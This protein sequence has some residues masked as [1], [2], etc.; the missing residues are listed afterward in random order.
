MS[1][2]NKGVTARIMLLCI[3]LL[4]CNAAI[5]Q[6]VLRITDANS[7]AVEDAF[8]SVK[9]ISFQKE[10][11]AFTDEKGIAKLPFG[12]KCQV[13]IKKL[14][15]KTLLT[16]TEIG[17]STIVHLEQDNH[18]LNDVV[19]T[20]QASAT[21][22]QQSINSIKVIDRKKID[23]MGAVS[24]RDALTNQLNVRLSQDNVLGASA[25][26]Q[27]VGGQGIK[28]LV[29]GVPV[30]G[31]MDGNVDLSQINLSNI[32]RIELIEGPMSVIYGSDALGGVI[33]L[34]S[35]RKVKEDISGSL[36]GYYESNGT[37]NADARFSFKWKEISFTTS[38]G[39]NF[40]DGYSP[41]FDP[42][43]RVVQWKPRTQYF[44]DNT[45]TFKIKQSKHAVF[46]NY[47]QEKITNRGAPSVNP[48]SAYG[49]DEYYY[50]RRWGIGEQSDLYLK[51]NNH[52]QFINSFSYYRRIKNTM[53]KDLTTGNSE[54]TPVSSDD[55]T[56]TFHLYL[57]RGTWTNTA[58]K[59][60]QFQ[61]GYDFNLE[62]AIGQRLE[63]NF[64][65]IQDYA[66]FTTVQYSPI[67]RVSL[68]AGV[69]GAYNTRYGTPVIPSFNLKVDISKVV[70]LR[71]SYAQG[72]RA[73]SLK[74]LGMFFVDV[75]HNI[76]GNNQLRAERSHNAQVELIYQPKLKDFSF[77]LRPLFFFNHIYNM[78]SLALVDPA[79]QL[80]TYV[81]I[82]KFQSTGANVNA[83]VTH[84]YF[85]FTAGMSYT[86]RY[87][88]LS[89][90]MDVP[91]FGW[92]PEF[93]SSLSV[94]IPKA[95]LSI[96]A[97]YKF[98]GAIP[99][100]TIDENNTVY[101]TAIQSYSMLDASVTARLWKERFVISVGAKNLLNVKSINYNT[102]SG[103][104]HSSG[105]SNMSIGMGITAFTSL[106]INLANNFKSN[107][108]ATAK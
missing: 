40:F 81:N 61:A 8:I 3:A 54:F 19:V 78:I 59:K 107:D 13:Q 89:E 93:S 1:A 95:Y 56:S 64:Q 29:D 86:G 24:L 105:N 46:S 10:C 100:Y 91:H 35:K 39:R 33:N 17:T 71:A 14:G 7:A 90:T 25:S 68:K 9:N 76:Q 32:E 6:F 21:T 80:Y 63:N 66:V 108:G 51:G 49:F 53:R 60:F 69:R 104:A 28:I 5:A 12:G 74:E 103:G 47:F 84:K 20:G 42:M 11:I 37:Y 16:E 106:K 82:D 65:N 79:A 70:S 72:F 52:L 2:N 96:A 31:R 43:K 62:T 38:G 57:F 22:A 94:N 45:F 55:D 36:N 48:Y 73:P 41:G 92:S 99:G 67:E 102:V 58:L 23:E 87:N 50:T 75:N 27:G 98:N 30:I 97:F 4:L 85:D 88:S 77:T 101:Q 34:I 15:Y 26:I 44:N 83:A 18:D